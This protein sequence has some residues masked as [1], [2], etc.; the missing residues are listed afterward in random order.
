MKADE[1][2]SATAVAF[3]DLDPGRS[4]S[5]CRRNSVEMLALRLMSD[6]P[7]APVVL[8]VDDEPLLR[9]DAVDILED[10]GFETVE[11]QTAKDAL[12]ILAERPD[13]RLLFTDV[14]MPGMSGIELAEQVH[15]HWP[16]ILL[17]VTSSDRAMSDRPLP[18]HGRFIAK[19]YEASKLTD[20]VDD[21]L[22]RH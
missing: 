19:P 3:L 11:A 5:G 1:R 6:K 12:A 20:E 4:K 7:D 14:N 21:L 17:I 10:K 2:L 16:K 18:D 9:M 22:K 13:V 15:L 8:V